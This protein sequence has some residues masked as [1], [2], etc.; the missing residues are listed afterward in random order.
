MQFHRVQHIVAHTAYAIAHHSITLNHNLML[1][2]IVAQCIL[3]AVQK[4]R[5]TLHHCV[6]NHLFNLIMTTLCLSDLYSVAYYYPGVNGHSKT[7]L[8]ELRVILKLTSVTIQ[9]SIDKQHTT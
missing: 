4:S 6:E 9:R 8:Y 3:Y 7:Q 2:F 5:R 1:T